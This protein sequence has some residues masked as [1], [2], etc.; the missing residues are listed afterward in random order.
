MRKTLFD[1]Y[2]LLLGGRILTE[3]DGRMIVRVIIIG[4]LVMVAL[5]LALLFIPGIPL[6]P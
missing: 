2:A 4:T 6:T 1:R 5:G 3:R